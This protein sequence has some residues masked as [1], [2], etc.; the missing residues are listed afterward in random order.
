MNKRKKLPANLSKA[1][2]LILQLHAEFGQKLSSDTAR[3]HAKFLSD[4]YGE[5]IA[6]P[7]PR[8]FQMGVLDSLEEQE[9]SIAPIP[10]FSMCSHH[11]LPFFGSAEIH[12]SP[13]PKRVLGLS[14]FYRIV[15]HLASKPQTQE[16]L[17]AEIIDTIGRIAKPS[18]VR[19]ATTAEHL[20]V[21]MRGVR[22][23]D[24]ATT[25]RQAKSF[26]PAHPT[27]VSDDGIADN[28]A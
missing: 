7:E 4:F 2:T 8:V 17:T 24:T 1:E 16:I 10:F 13:H 20:C 27:E 19:V 5:G 21:A 28:S 12:Y 18:Y 23:V 14:K 26:A 9:V 15:Q 22:V 11:L 6:L 3:R 25:V